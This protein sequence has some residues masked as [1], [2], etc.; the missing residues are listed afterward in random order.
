MY[1]HIEEYHLN[2][3]V[4]NHKAFCKAVKAAKHE[5]FD[6]QIKEIATSNKRHMFSWT[7]LS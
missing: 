4:E 7:A 2:E 3:T 1:R 6:E 5:F